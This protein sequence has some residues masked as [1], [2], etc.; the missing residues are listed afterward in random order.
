MAVVLSWGQL[1]IFKYST[2]YSD[3]FLFHKI[4]SQRE[5]SRPTDLKP[6]YFFIVQKENILLIESKK[7]KSPSIYINTSIAVFIAPVNIFYLQFCN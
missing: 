5:H 1:L 6:I 4:F 7:K 3:E 2:V